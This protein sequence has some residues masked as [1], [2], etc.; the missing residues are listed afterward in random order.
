MDR[1]KLD[2]AKPVC[3]NC[4]HFQNDPAILEKTW[5]G[6]ASMS[7]GFASVRAEDG[8]CSHHNLYLSNRDS[9][10]DFAAASR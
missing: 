9:C 3:G 2:H 7:S 5:P 1:T 4:I 8:L 10:A 6:L